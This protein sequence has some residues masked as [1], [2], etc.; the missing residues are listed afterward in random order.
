MATTIGV[1]DAT[2]FATQEVRATKAFELPP[3]T[4]TFIPIVA[5]FTSKALYPSSNFHFY[6]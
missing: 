2:S 1:K 5:P 6:Y 3:S 4:P